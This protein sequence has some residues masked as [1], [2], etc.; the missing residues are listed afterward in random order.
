M[1][2]RHVI[3]C[4]GCPMLLNRSGKWGCCKECSGLRYQFLRRELHGVGPND[5]IRGN[6]VVCSSRRISAAVINYERSAPVGAV[7]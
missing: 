1:S 3:R 2:H 6:N 4:I 5:W 7:S